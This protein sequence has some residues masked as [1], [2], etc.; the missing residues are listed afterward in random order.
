MPKAREG[1]STRF[2]ISHARKENGV[3]EIF[4][5]MI[6]CIYDVNAFWMRFGTRMLVVLANHMARLT[7]DN[8]K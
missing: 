4:L 8:K 6:A 7:L 1:E 2:G 3:R 5:F